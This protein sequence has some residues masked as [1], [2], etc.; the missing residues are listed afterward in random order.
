MFVQRLPIGVTNW[1]LFS[2]LL[3][4]IDMCNILKSVLGLYK[5]ASTDPDN[6][7][8]PQIGRFQLPT[9]RGGDLA[10]GSGSCGGDNGLADNGGHSG[11]CPLLST[12]VQGVASHPKP[13]GLQLQPSLPPE[14]GSRCTKHQH[15]YCTSPLLWRFPKSWNPYNVKPV[16]TDISVTVAQIQKIQKTRCIFFRILLLGGPS[17]PSHLVPNPFN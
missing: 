10:R 2:C 16:S 11:L 12:C 5:L 14:S 7:L 17:P 8:D 13:P 9:D 1:G 3:A 15:A 4:T 6:V